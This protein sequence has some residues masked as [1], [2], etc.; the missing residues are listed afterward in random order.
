[1]ASGCKSQLPNHQGRSFGRSLFTAPFAAPM[2][3]HPHIKP[4]SSALFHPNSRARNRAMMAMDKR[5]CWEGYIPRASPASD[6]PTAGAYGDVSVPAALGLRCRKGAA[7]GS[8]SC[9]RRRVKKRK[10]SR[11]SSRM[12]LSERDRRSAGELRHGCF[13][14]SVL[15]ALEKVRQCSMS[16][17]RLTTWPQYKST[18]RASTYSPLRRAR[19][20]VNV[21]YSFITTPVTT[22]TRIECLIARA[23]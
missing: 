14:L 16:P 4:P 22:N 10:R 21:S 12:V 9:R 19:R 6:A 7:E 2:A 8:S 1:M 11:W 18:S 23:L 13:F 20:A 3:S 5:S 15:G 17:A